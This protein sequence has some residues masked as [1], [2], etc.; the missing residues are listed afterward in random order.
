MTSLSFTANLCLACTL[1]TQSNQSIMFESFQQG[2]PDPMFFLKKAADQDPSPEK[3][4]L[5]VGIYRNESG[6]YSELQAVAQ[7]C[8]SES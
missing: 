3:T 8:P 1:Q 7:V 5:G 2:P 6:H 4:D